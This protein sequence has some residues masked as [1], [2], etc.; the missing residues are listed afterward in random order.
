MNTIAKAT[1][2]VKAG[3]LKSA[4]QICRQVLSKDPTNAAA[5]GLLGVIAGRTGNHEAA[6]TLLQ[7]ASALAP[8]VASHQC[9]YVRALI[10]SER[11]ETAEAAAT[12]ALGHVPSHPELLA[13]KG[14][15]CSNL[16]KSDVAVELLRK[17]VALDDG[18]PLSWFNLSEAHRRNG[19]HE[20]ARSCVE[21]ALALAPEYPDALNNYAGL[22][23]NAGEFVQAMECI[24]KLLKVQPRSAQAYVNLGHA[25]RMGGAIE[26]A[27]TSYENAL[28]LDEKCDVAM[29]ELA[30]LHVNT[31]EFELAHKYL[32]M[33]EALD[34]DQTRTTV[35]K[36]RICERK[37][38]ID[39]A[40][41][42]TAKL[43]AELQD[44]AGVA[45]CYATVQEQLG[46]LE[47]AAAA[48]ESVLERSETIAADGIGIH[49]SLGKIYDAL[50]R[51]DEAFQNYQLGNENRKKA[52]VVP[53]SSEVSQRNFEI[54]R[55]G[56]SVERYAS[57]PAAT[58]TSDRPIF[59]VGMPRSGTS[60]T[61]QILSS[62]PDVFGG[63]ELSIMGRSGQSDARSRARRGGEGFSVF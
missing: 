31:G 42:L 38:D 54:L 56:Y 16:G 55:D 10:S 60:L 19:E 13:L 53:Y 28:R 59:I 2:A 51:H 43:Y 46:N 8:R 11:F 3:N 21:K 35:L 1:T 23:L 57:L 63:G 30:S 15:A 48:L 14:I 6:A 41:R 49:F 39:E 44:D 4:E 52:F 58:V 29:N 32:S 36:A 34:E 25:C 12:L 17:S 50:K 47:S 27:V 24:E 9:N 40:D 20:E 18:S 33:L 22:L 7:R 37:G 5:V 62:H 26:A 45:M 61:E